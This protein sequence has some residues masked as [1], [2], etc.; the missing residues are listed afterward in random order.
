LTKTRQA[1]LHKL[2]SMPAR[3]GTNRKRQA[4]IKKLHK[5]IAACGKR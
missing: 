1:R 4:L 5:Q 2:R 3:K